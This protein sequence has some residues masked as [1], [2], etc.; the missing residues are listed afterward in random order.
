MALVLGF[1]VGNITGSRTP[2]EPG[3]V[4]N[5][6]SA[7]SNNGPGQLDAERI[8]VGNSPVLGPANALA[9]I[10]IFSDYQCPFCSRVEETLQR[11]RREYPNDV[12]FVWKDNPLPFHDKATPAAEAA[13]EAFAQGGNEKFWRFHDLMFQNQQN[14]ERA[15]LERYATQVGLNM[16][17]FRAA[18][19]GHTHTA[20]IDRDK[21]LATTINAQGTPNFFINGSNIVGAQPYEK[22]KELVD[23]VLAR[24]RTITPRNEVYRRMVADPDRR[25]RRRATPT[26]PQAPQRQEDPNAVYNV[27]VGNSPAQGPAN[28]LVTLV[29]FS[30]FQCPFCSRVET[31]IPRSAPAT[32]TTS[33]WCGRTSRSPSTTAPGRRPTRRWRPS[34]RAGPPSSGRCMTCS[35]STS[36]TSPT[37][38]SSATPRRWAS[39]WT[40]TARR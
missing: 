18:L 10:V 5:E 40:A 2:S 29:L 1:V 12:R 39:T 17:R 32:A 30:D 4:T 37:P 20:A 3:G 24:A 38:T 19:D 23:A 9:T 27:P 16:T 8:P 35:W 33:A 15:D 36:R 7:P 31:T 34:R 26:Q 22:F 13:R 28:A 21:Q 6:A 25:P 11:I 14:L